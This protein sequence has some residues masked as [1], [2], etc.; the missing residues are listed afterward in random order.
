MTHRHCEVPADRAAEDLP[1]V[2]IAN[3]LERGDLADWQP[4]AAAIGRD[5]WC[6]LATAV[7]RLI[8]VYPR[9]GTSP[10]WRAWIDRCR[11]RAQAAPAA[12]Q[13]AAT[14]RT[15]TLA[16]LR[17]DLGLTQAQV[18]RRLRM[19]QSDVSKLERR[20]NVRLSTLQAYARALG[21]QLT[22][23]FVGGEQAR[24]IRLGRDG[25]GT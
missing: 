14:G 17:R 10:L 3:I 23:T 4:L 7:R 2:A 8:D 12:E 15:V 21:G 13:V 18:A 1:L 20:E 16:A 24:E 6:G 11:A 25:T 22:V 5:P 9:Y 19:T